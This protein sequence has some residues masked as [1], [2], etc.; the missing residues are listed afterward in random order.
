[1]EEVKTK[2]LRVE[3]QRE[4]TRQ[5]SEKPGLMAFNEFAASLPALAKDPARRPELR[6]A[7]ASVLDKLVLDPH[8]DG[9]GA[10]E[11]EVI[12]KGA[13]KPIR[14]ICNTQPESWSFRSELPI[15]A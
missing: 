4:Q 12:L 10:W 15:A 6:R 2:Q 3:V 7:I 1:L 14:I 11:Y 8:G 13:N 9:N 5:R